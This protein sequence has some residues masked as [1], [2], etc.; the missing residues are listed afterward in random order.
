MNIYL[1]WLIKTL[2][3]PIVLLIVYAISMYIYDPFQF[4]HKAWF[5][6]V[7]FQKD[8][9]IQAI[10]IIKHYGDFNSIILGS[11]LLKNTSAKEANEKLKGEWRNFSMLGS[12]FSERAILLD[13]LF[14]YKNI[15][16]IIYSLDGYS[17]VNPKKDIDV[18]FISFYNSNSL[19]PYIKFYINKHFFFCL[20]RFSN[21]ENCV[22][23]KLN[24]PIQTL[25]SKRWFYGKQFEYIKNFDTTTINPNNINLD[26]QKKYIKLNLLKY[27][28]KYP[29]TQFYII[30]PPLP[31]DFYKFTIHKDYYGYFESPIY[32][33]KLKILTKW[34]LE[35]TKNN[36]NVTFYGFD[37]TN[38]PDNYTNYTD[39]IHYKPDMNSIQ[40]N[41]IKNNTN[42][43]TLD[44]ID[45]YFSYME[46]KI[47]QFD[48]KKIKNIATEQRGL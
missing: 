37:N 11:S 32:F 31:R 29:K 6:E 17:L 10:G 45:Q 14:K 30:I 34:I 13:Y 40:L 46:K 22:G 27:I 8:M 4:F 28:Q 1:R 48:M 43:I 20:L 35:Q 24:Q 39:N 26:E 25:K 7:S 21:S 18:K 3:I 47:Q 2:L 41:A 15:N 42:R 9:R 19:I 44:N 16:N 12:Y 38:Y 36:Y 5:R 33:T 23:E